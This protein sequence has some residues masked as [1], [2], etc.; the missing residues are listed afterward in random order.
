MLILLFFGGEEIKMK[1]NGG[2]WGGAKVKIKFD[3]NV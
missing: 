3:E 2:D 1:V